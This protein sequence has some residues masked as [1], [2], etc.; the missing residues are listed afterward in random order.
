MIIE[1]IINYLIIIPVKFIVWAIVKW[2]EKSIIKFAYIVWIILIT[3]L[4]IKFNS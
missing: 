1:K 2:L 4:I 3:Y